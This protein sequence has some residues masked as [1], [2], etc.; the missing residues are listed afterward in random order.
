MAKRAAATTPEAADPRRPPIP[1]WEE[2]TGADFA[3]MD[4]ERTIVLVS[5]SPMEVHGPHLP[6]CTDV[7]EAEGLGRRAVEILLERD[8]T[9]RFVRLPPL[10]VA[11]D[12]VPQPGS[13]MFRSSTT[14]RVLSDMGRSL[15]RQG[16]RHIWVSNF[17]GG[18]R[19][20]VPIDLAAHRTNRRYGASMISVFG[21]LMN[22]LTGGRSDLG[23][24][25]GHIP[26]LSREELAGDSH[27]GA[28]ETS[29]MLHLM[30]QH[31]AP[32][33]ADLPWVTVSRKM[34]AQGL[35]PLVSEGRPS[36]RELV[37]G[38]RHT[39]K[40]FEDET[41]AG[42]PAIASAAIGAEVLDV[43]A[44][45]TA[46]ALGELLRGEIRPEDCYSPLWP[47]RWLF[48]SET[49]GWAFERLVGFRT[50]VF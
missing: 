29:M 49:L 16:F 22:R 31:V 37:R 34:A 50:Q 23:D 4:R 44:T 18:P 7:C 36:L 3:A 10:W 26:G 6:V 13:V 20:F 42:K 12:V 39:I 38:F 47:A 48:L 14:V 41:Y 45:L 35:R 1:R 21:L 5:S 11:A 27:G 30:G 43:L 17:H 40:Y 33:Y 32:G 46:D 9:L 2:L 19:H 15:A 25:L 28:V 8:P 24:V